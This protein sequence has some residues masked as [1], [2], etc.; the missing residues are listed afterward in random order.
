MALD[1]ILVFQYCINKI[2]INCF[3]LPCS[4]D[5]LVD[6]IYIMFSRH[7]LY[8]IHNS[9][10]TVV[11]GHEWMDEKLCNINKKAPRQRLHRVL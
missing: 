1:I 2:D 11:F 9:Y 10:Y 4:E 3:T 8:F 6:I 5:E 7:S